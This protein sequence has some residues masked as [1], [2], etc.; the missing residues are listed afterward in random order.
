MNSTLTTHWTLP[1]PLLGATVLWRIGICYFISEAAKVHGQS[2][3]DGWRC[4]STETPPSLSRYPQL[5][6]QPHNQDHLVVH[7]SPSL[8]SHAAAHLSL[9]I[10]LAW[11]PVCCRSRVRRG[12]STLPLICWGSRTG[13]KFFCDIYFL[14]SLVRRL[15]KSFMYT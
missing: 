8:H 3:A 9:G 14:L 15:M 12:T 7:C 13:Q 6:V 2:D 10:R 4:S 5:L 11:K 1:A